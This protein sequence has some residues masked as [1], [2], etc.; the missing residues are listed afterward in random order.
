MISCLCN[1]GTMYTFLH[2]ESTLFHFISAYHNWFRHHFI[3]FESGQ[4]LW[5]KCTLVWQKALQFDMGHIIDRG[6]SISAGA[7][8]LSKLNTR[9]RLYDPS[10]TVVHYV[11]QVWTCRK[12][13]LRFQT[14][15]RVTKSIA[16]CRIEMKRCRFGV[17]NGV[18]TGLQHAT[19]LDS[20]GALDPEISLKNIHT[21]KH[22]YIHTWHKSD[23]YRLLDS[24]FAPSALSLRLNN[25]VP[26]VPEKS[27]LKQISL[28]FLSHMRYFWKFACS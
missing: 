25:Y 16:I 13:L 21:N 5:T 2:A 8:A 19:T 4:P 12:R 26:G 14:N 18:F 22:T 3:G 17:Q 6:H 20:L 27:R 10:R 11:I 24:G 28:N 1:V 23:F 9:C 15:M 7:S